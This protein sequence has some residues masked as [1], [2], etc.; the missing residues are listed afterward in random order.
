M[1]TPETWKKDESQ[2]KLKTWTVMAL[3]G[4]CI[5]LFITGFFVGQYNQTTKWSNNMKGLVSICEGQSQVLRIR[6]DF[7]ALVPQC[8]G[9]KPLDD[10]IPSVI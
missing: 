6:N 4:L 8:F 2:K 9:V 5:A 3:I 1:G 7:G 10:R